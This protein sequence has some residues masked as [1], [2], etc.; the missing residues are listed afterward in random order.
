M[1]FRVRRPNRPLGGKELAFQGEETAHKAFGGEDSEL[2]TF[3]GEE[4]AL[5]Q[6][7]RW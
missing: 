2:D 1:P 4:T 5:A 7:F 6:A 3:Q